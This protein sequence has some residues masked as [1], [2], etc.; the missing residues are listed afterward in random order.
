MNEKSESAQTVL[1]KEREKG[2]EEKGRKIKMT[3]RNQTLFTCPHTKC[4]SFNY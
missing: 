2:Q 3:S 4:L 1:I